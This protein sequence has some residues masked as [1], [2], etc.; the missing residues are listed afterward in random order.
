[1]SKVLITGGTGMIGLKLSEKL[2]Q[3][4]FQVIHLSRTENKTARFPRYAWDVDTG[5]MDEKALEGIETIVHLAGAAIN[6]RWTEKNKKEIIDS[7]VASAKL[8]YQTAQKTGNKLKRFVSMSAIGYYGSDTGD[9]LISESHQ[10]G[11]DFLAEV[12][13]K[14]E[15]AADQFQSICPVTKLRTGVVLA[16]EGGALPTIAKP[17]RFGI[18]SPIGSG[19]QWTSWIHIDDVIDSFCMAIEGKLKGTYNLVAPH[20]VTNAELSQG[21]ADILDKP[22]FFPNVPSFVL[23]ILFG[24]MAAIILGGN[25]VS[26]EQLTSAG[27]T[28]TYPDLKPALK[29]L[30]T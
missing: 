2:L 15:A 27:Y 13:T 12:V 11:D 7:R 9:E 22:F 21:I 19:K 20:P 30:L 1:M 5:T 28:F 6:Q 29:D 26:N 18:G 8:L 10:P 3:K 14:W 16:S 17:I 24:K 23:K 4:G 25:K